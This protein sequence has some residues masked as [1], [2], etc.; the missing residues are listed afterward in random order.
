MTEI[1][2]HPTAIVEEGAQ[3]GPG[4]SIWHHAHVR[5]GAVIGSGSTLGKNVFV[6]AGA[7]VGARCKI[8][9]N[10]SV[11]SGVVLEDDVFVGPS[12]VFT[13]D[14]F[15]R[16]F[17]RWET[18]TTLV[19]RGASIGANATLRC[20]IELGELCMVAAGAMVTRDVRANEL[21]GGNP[22]RTLGWVDVRG[23]VV[24][25]APERPHSLPHGGID[26]ETT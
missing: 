19:R 14:L 3:I 22:A 11:Y 21:V 6:D 13:N 25:R 17:G 12:A 23:A 10:V 15:P 7:R 26:E 5:A 16:A 8:Q 4:T 24:S 20:G 9:N 18:V 1:R 2:I